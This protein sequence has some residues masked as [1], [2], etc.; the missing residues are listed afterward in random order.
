MMLG[1][2]LSISP[3]LKNGDLKSK[4]ANCQEHFENDTRY[5]CNFAVRF[6]RQKER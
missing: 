5:L 3:Y 6:M 2:I 1:M 4:S